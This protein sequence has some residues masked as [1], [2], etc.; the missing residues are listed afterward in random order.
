MP[1]TNPHNSGWTITSCYSFPLAV[2][3]QR[4]RSHN[5]QV[6]HSQ[7]R[8]PK[9]TCQGCSPA[10]QVLLQ[11]S[12]DITLA[13]GSLWQDKPSRCSVG[14]MMQFVPWPQQWAAQFRFTS[15]HFPAAVLSQP[16]RPKLHEK[17]QMKRCTP[18]GP[19]SHQTQAASRPW[20]LMRPLGKHHKE[21]RL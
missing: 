6:T 16:N 14:T 18:S 1:S 7:T 19:A 20:F 15:W 13:C 8:L 17:Q 5:T 12:T 2:S 11:H 9:T 4:L 3:T 10:S 21:P